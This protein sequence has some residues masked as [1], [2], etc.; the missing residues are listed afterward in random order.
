MEIIQMTGN[1]TNICGATI[2][3]YL[4]LG[5]TYLSLSDIITENYRLYEH[6]YMNKYTTLSIRI[7]LTDYCRS[8]TI[9]TK[10]QNDL[11]HSEN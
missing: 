3:L 6:S 11:F 5:I 10:N 2:T 8:V 1:V 4:Y 9:V 7:P